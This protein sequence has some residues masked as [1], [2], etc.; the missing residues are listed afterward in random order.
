MSVITSSSLLLSPFEMLALLMF[1]VLTFS[2]NFFKLFIICLYSL[3]CVS[4]MV[5]SF[6]PKGLFDI[7]VSIVLVA[8]QQKSKRRNFE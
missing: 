7:N 4:V 6:K 2:V 3:R 1:S 8:G 5:P